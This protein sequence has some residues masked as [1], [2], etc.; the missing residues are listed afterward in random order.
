VCGDCTDKAVVERVMGGERADTLVSDPPYGIGYEYDVHSDASNE[1]NKH[2]VMS[3]WKL[4]PDAKVWTP[5]LM[6]L[7][8]DLIW[9]PGAKVLC[10]HKGFAQAGSGLGGAST[11]EPVLVVNVKGGTLPDDYLHFG[12]DRVNGLR[13]LHSCPKPIALFEHLIEH[14]A[15]ELIYE[16]FSGSG[17]TI[18]ACERLGRKCRAVEISPAYCAVAIQRWVDVTGGEPVLLSN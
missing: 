18:I 12:T 13:E 6:N 11:W 10:W 5:G 3:S 14:L 8:R 17:T 15:G 2:L 16:P 7:E 9:N 4:A 1:Q